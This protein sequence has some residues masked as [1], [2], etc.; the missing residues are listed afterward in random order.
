[1]DLDK[2]LIKVTRYKLSYDYKYDKKENSFKNNIKNNSIDKFELFYENHYI[3]GTNSVQTVSNHPHFDFYDTIAPGKFQMQCFIT[4]RKFHGQIHGIINAFDLENQ[5]IDHWS[6][7]IENGY[8]KGRWLDHDRWSFAKNRDLKFGYSGGCFV[9]KSQ[10]LKVYNEK[11]K[12]MLI[13]PGD[14][15]NGILLEE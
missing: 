11:L 10:D 1:M 6:M 12:K 4:P 7:Q 14:V 15:L 5:K 2:F 3:W 9:K 13:K 8:Q